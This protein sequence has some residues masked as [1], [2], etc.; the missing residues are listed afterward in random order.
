[1]HLKKRFA[2][3]ALAAL[4]M[5]SAC[6]NGTLTPTGQQLVT[7]A[8]KVDETVVPVAAPVLLSSVPVAATVDQLLVHP[9]VV[10]ICNGLG[11][12]PATV[13]PVPATAPPAPAVPAATPTS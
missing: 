13:T 2:F 4:P 1:M 9:T 10:D 11:G 8:C 12:T 6:A 5:L 3:A 7:I